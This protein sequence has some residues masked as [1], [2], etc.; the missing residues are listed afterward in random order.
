MSHTKRK[1][2]RKHGGVLVYTAVGMVAFAGF[3]S[4]GVDVAH[5]R[6]VKI[7]LQNA[8]DA[9]ARYAVTGMQTSLAQA[10]NN[11]VAAA[12]DNTAD[13]TT[14]VVDSNQD[15][16]FGTWDPSN[17][18]FTVLAGQQQSSANAVR[19]WVRRTAARGDPVSLFFGPVIG[20]STSDVTVS[21]IAMYTQPT[22]TGVIGLD[23]ITTHN[24]LFVGSYDS[25]ATTTPTENSAGSNAAMYS[26]G[27][28]SGSGTEQG[29]ARLGPNG[30]VSGITVTG[31]TTNSSTPISVP[32]V[33]MQVVTNPGGVSQAP[34]LSNGQTVTWPA[35][36]YYFTSLTLAN[37]ISINF[38][39]PAT[40][41]L[42]GNAD[43]HDNNTITA[44]N[45]VPGNLKIIQS[46]GNTFTLHD[47]NS[48]YAQLISPGGALNFAHDND[49]WY[50]S[51]VAQS[52]LV[53][54]NDSF[55]YDVQITQPG[56]VATV[57]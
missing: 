50:G 31:S 53:H 51:V 22:P 23:S 9:S 20:K 5:V 14:V 25:S 16:D 19:V 8:A 32:G 3:V 10:K 21:S 54:D 36:T 4:L 6:T 38:A 52:I 17:K 24:H 55:F 29:N 1:L 2:H 35:G 28:I 41:Y 13:G 30:S 12:A 40:I 27:A 57:Q 46:S 18:T 39:G 47:N 42:D 7:Q 33:T 48:V 11:A 45:G 34:N 56:G 37:N 44:Y 43:I 26:N 15:V 49:S